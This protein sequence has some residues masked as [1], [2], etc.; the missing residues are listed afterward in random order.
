MASVPE[1]TL[2]EA[3][4]LLRAA[5]WV[6][7]PPP[8]PSAPEPM[9]GQTWVSP[10]PRVEAR[11]ITRIGYHSHWPWAAD[12]CVYFTTP[13]GRGAC[14]NPETWAQWVQRSQARPV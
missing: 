9:T 8:S 7:V 14:V 2:T 13:S 11:T 1:T 4:A 6:V 12:A 10:K 3:A 5:G